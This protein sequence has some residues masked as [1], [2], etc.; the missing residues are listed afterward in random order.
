MILVLLNALEPISVMPSGKLSLVNC[1]PLK[2][3]SLI[4]VNVLGNT[5]SFKLEPEKA[6]APISVTPSGI[7]NFSI[8]VPENNPPGIVFQF[9]RST[10]SL[11]LFCPLNGE[12][13]DCNSD[14]KL[15]LI[16]ELK[17][18]K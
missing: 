14:G 6:P 16:R 9:P 10:T 3:E 1:V 12:I 2:A 17:S 4:F 5:T 18:L 7:T 8:P 11:R 15:T 13:V